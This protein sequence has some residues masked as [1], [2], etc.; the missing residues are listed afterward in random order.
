MQAFEKASARIKLIEFGDQSKHRQPTRK[1]FETG[2]KWGL[3]GRGPSE[4]KVSRRKLDIYSG[5]LHTSLVAD[6]ESDPWQDGDSS[7]KDVA[8]EDTRNSEEGVLGRSVFAPLGM[9][10]P[11]RGDALPSVELRLS[12]ES[13]FFLRTF[14]QE[15]RRRIIY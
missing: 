6:N 8:Y 1:Q 15:R 5:P 4:T 14:V 9:S 2:P 12:K 3:M 13:S 11:T 10:S 7:S